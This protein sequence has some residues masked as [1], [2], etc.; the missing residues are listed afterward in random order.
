MKRQVTFNQVKGIFGFGLGDPI[1]KI[2]FP[3]IQAAPSFSSSFPLIFNG[4]KDIP[5][6]IPCAI[7]QDPYFRMTRDVAPKLKY[8]KPA[9]L[10]SSFLPAL[11][12]A[13]TKMSASIDTTSIFLTDNEQQIAEKIEKYAHSA[14][15]DCDTDV[16]FQY[17]S[18]FLDDQTQLEQIKAD[19]TDHKITSR[20]VK[21]LIIHVLQRL[22]ADF[23][24]KRKDVTDEMVAQFCAPRKLNYDF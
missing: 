1:G 9:L 20:Q 17:L 16:A 18:Y 10:H 14:E 19:Y 6:L 22:V 3:A 13:Q 7:D 8:P 23:Q 11:S 15:G 12:G 2:D 4:K 21:Q 24:M 5:C